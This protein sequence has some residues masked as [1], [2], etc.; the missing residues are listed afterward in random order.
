VEVDVPRYVRLIGEGKFDESYA[1]V[2]ESLPLPSVCSYICLSFCEEQCRRGEVN[3][4]IGIKE[5]KRFVSEHH[6]D[7]WKE[8]IK[9]PE[10]TGKRAAIL[11]SGPAGLTAAY[12]LARK[13][14]EVTIF[15]QAPMSGGMLRKAISRKRLPKEALEDDI[16]EILSMGVVLK[17]NARDITIDKLLEDGFDTVLLAIGTTFSGPTAYWLKEEDIDLTDR[18]GIEVESYDMSTSREGVFAAGDAA[19]GGISE[20]FIRYTRSDDYYDDFFET[21]TETLVSDRGDSYRSATWAIASGK[22][23]AEYMDQYLGGDGDLKES[24]LPP[25][26][27]RDPY[28]GLEKG[29]AN[30]ERNAAAYQARVPQYAGLNPAEPPIIEEEAVSEAKRCLK[31]DL[32]FSIKPPKFWG[33]Y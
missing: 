31:C 32:R 11:G 15:E 16:N 29:F 4:P 8:G 7:L 14:H 28:L 9:P 26:G 12:Y 18:G 17:L 23:A 33:D 30:L 21:L 24:F 22:K 3:E 25:E 20:D 27:E 13:G 19:S 2:R 10:A 6:T 1:V 5:L